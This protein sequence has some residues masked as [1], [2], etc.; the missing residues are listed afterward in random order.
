MQ[1]IA[2]RVKAAKSQ[3]KRASDLAQRVVVKGQQSTS[4]PRHGV[5]SEF[6]KD[7]GQELSGFADSWGNTFA[8]M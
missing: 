3:V 4:S 7:H 5:A 8:K 6:E 2:D 1:R